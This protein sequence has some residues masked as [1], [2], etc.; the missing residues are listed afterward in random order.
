MMTV[1]EG[2]IVV[3]EKAETAHAGRVVLHT[4]AAPLGNETDIGWARASVA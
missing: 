4:G 3:V 2:R 1:I